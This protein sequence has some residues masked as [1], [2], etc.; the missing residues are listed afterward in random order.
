M[1]SKK[2]IN[3]KIITVALIIMS[4]L[5]MVCLRSIVFAIDGIGEKKSETTIGGVTYDVYEREIQVDDDDDWEARVSVPKYDENGVLIQYE[6]DE[7]TVPTGYTKTVDGM[8]IRNTLNNYNYSVEYYY[9]NEKDETATVTTSNPYGATISTYTDKVKDGYILDNVDNLNMK[10]DTDESKNIIKVYYKTQTDSLSGTINW[11][12]N[13]NALSTRPAKYTLKLLADGTEVKSQEFDSA[14]GTWEFTNIQKYAYSD[15]HEIVYTVEEDEI[16]IANGDKYVP[17]IS[18]TTVTNKI[19]GITNLEIK[20]VWEDN[21]NPD[22]TRPEAI[23]VV[24]KSLI[25]K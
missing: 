11:I 8:T 4:M 23:T 19:T 20:K 24:L 3:K 9:D 6:L 18:G 21:N 14:E 5:S 16:T 1:K 13:S 2:L 22:N 12:D 17:T 10:V 25:S 7:K 15:G